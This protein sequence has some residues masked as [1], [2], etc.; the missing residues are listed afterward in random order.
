VLPSSCSIY[1][2]LDEVASES[3]PTNPLTTYAKANE[4]A[5]FGVL[6]QSSADFCVAVMRQATVF[7][8]SP[9]MRFDLAV[10]G[11]TYGAYSNKVLPL[12]RDGKQYRPMLHVQDTTDVMCLLLECDSGLVNGEI[13]NVGSA[14]NNYQLGDLGQRVARQVGELLNEEIKVEWYGDPDHR[15]YQV[16]FS[17]IE[18]TLGWKAAWNAERGV[19][20]IVAALQAGTLDKTPETIT[21]DWYKQLVFWAN[22]LRGMEIYGGL[23]ELAD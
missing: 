15:S 21:L 6:E 23:L 16:D 5:E 2:F 3:T 20:E 13:F 11:M 22:K 14:E 8:A 19:K 4:Q 18:R 9:R 1:G 17:K 10:N 7:G 12:M